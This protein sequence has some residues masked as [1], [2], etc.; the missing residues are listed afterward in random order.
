MRI[1]NIHINECFANRS[2]N[3]MDINLDKTISCSGYGKEQFDYNDIEK[4]SF[5]SLGIIYELLNAYKKGYN[6]FLFGAEPG[7]DIFCAQEVI[8][9]NKRNPDHKFKVICVLPYK[10][11]KNLNAF[12]KF[13]RKEYNET[14]T[15][16][17]EVIYFGDG[18]Y[19]G[20]C[21]RRRDDWIFIRSSIIISYYKYEGLPKYNEYKTILYNH[22]RHITIINLISYTS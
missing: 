21:F 10:N 6:T 12:N 7:F 22:G 9:H 20:G 3:V 15:K 16:C 14:I 4:I 8:K 19:R 13:W 17:D 5:I 1:R 18:Q 2:D 11:Y